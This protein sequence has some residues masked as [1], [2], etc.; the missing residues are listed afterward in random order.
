MTSTSG[1]DCSNTTL[2]EQCGIRP[3]CNVNMLQEIS[4]CT[5]F[6]KTS[7]KCKPLYPRQ[8]QIKTEWSRAIIIII[9]RF[10]I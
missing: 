7:E 9:I 10:V 4:T 6:F 3:P 1:F 5:F 8:H 2:V